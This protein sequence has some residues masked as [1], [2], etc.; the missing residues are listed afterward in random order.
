MNP[1][2]LNTVVT[3]VAAVIPK[4]VVDIYD[5]FFNDE[6]LQVR[7]KPDKTKLTKQNY[8][9]AH[10]AY[11]MYKKPNSIY[12]GQAQLVNT[13]NRWFGTNK[14]IAQMM[15]VCRSEENIE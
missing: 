6:E 4:A 7:K 15:R 1:L 14:S 11:K 12:T 2:L 5:Y 3:A 8:I 13:L 9:D 10:A